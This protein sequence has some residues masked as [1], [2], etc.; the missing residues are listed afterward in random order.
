MDS[1]LVLCRDVVSVNSLFCCVRSAWRRHLHCWT[2]RGSAQDGGARHD[3]QKELHILN[4][5]LRWCRDGVVFAAHAKRAREAID[6]LGLRKSKPVPSPVVADDAS[7]YHAD[8]RR[9]LD[10][11]EKQL[12]QRI[13]AKLNYLAHDWLDL[14]CATSCLTSAASAP[15][16]GDLQAAKRVG[17]YLRKVPVAWLKFTFWDPRPGVLL[18]YADRR[19]ARSLGIQSELEDL[20]SSCSVVVAT[21]SQS[22]IAHARRRDHSVA[23]KH[24][25]LR[26]LWLR[27]AV[28]DKKLTLRKCTP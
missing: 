21:G 1:S 24:V 13:A 6:E 19:R 27:G 28:G 26:G 8:N 11:T 5:T 3:D 4:R 23:S 20:G 10:E 17:R 15:N 12:Y 18:C 7:G 22:V 9:L 2:S 14:R 16:L 25:G